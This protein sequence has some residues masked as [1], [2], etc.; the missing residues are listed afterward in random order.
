MEVN[1]WH[2]DMMNAATTALQVVLGVVAH[3]RVTVTD[4]VT[5]AVAV[6]VVVAAIIAVTDAMGAVAG[7]VITAVVLVTQAVRAAEVLALDLVK[8]ARDVQEPAPD[9]VQGRVKTPARIALVNVLENATT[10][11]LRRIP[12]R[13]IITSV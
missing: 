7:A 6:A 5:V 8:D 12:I 1:L 4:H 10:A 13:F 11:V 3:V 9:L 2:A